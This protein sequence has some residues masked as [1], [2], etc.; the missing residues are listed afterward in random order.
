MR[1]YG[2][3]WLVYLPSWAGLIIC[4]FFNC[5]ISLLNYEKRGERVKELQEGTR[6]RPKELS[7]EK[8]NMVSSKNLRKHRQER[9]M[10]DLYLDVEEQG[11]NSEKMKR[12]ILEHQKRSTKQY[13]LSVGHDYSWN[14]QQSLPFMPKQ[15]CHKEMDM[16]QPEPCKEKKRKSDYIKNLE[17]LEKKN[18]AANQSSK[19]LLRTLAKKKESIEQSSGEYQVECL[20][21]QAALPEHSYSRDIPS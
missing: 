11:K 10:F 12:N 5:F 4:S 7:K 19:Y 21:V 8:V 6:K 3:A 20:E 17:Q 9:V 15:K 14:K 18:G 13:I 1:G 16:K 2:E